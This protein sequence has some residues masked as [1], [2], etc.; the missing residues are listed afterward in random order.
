MAFAEES[1]CIYPR[2]AVPN[3][4]LWA[5][6]VSDLSEARFQESVKRGEV[7]RARSIDP[8]EGGRWRLRWTRAN[9][10][11]RSNGYGN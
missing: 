11:T 6:D 1:C 9:D 3:P 4:R 10:G 2:L 8:L 5:I 7:L